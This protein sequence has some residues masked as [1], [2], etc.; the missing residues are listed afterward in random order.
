MT[1]KQITADEF[2]K[3]PE[4]S[5]YITKSSTNHSFSIPEETPYWYAFLEPPY[6][7]ELLLKDF[8]TFN[9]V[10]FPFPENLI[11]YRFNDEF[12]NYFDDGKEWWGTGCWSIYDKVLQT[13]V[14]ILAST[15]D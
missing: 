3:E 5:Y 4:D 15:T 14:V 10:L 2:F 1:A 12:S 8:Q 13:Y 7:N 6:S 11:L 9:A